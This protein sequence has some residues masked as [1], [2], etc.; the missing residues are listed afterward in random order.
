MVDSHDD[1]M[2]RLNYLWMFS[3]FSAA[4]HVDG[5]MLLFF[6]LGDRRVCIPGLF[7]PGCTFLLMA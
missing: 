2:V 6:I 4:P 3:T 5:V 1:V 7:C